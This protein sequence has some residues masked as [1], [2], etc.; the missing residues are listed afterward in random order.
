MLS[1]LSHHLESLAEALESGA[2]KGQTGRLSLSDTRRLSPVITLTPVPCHSSSPGSLGLSCCL[3]R[4]VLPPPLRP[5]MLP[6][7][8]CPMGPWWSSSL[9]PTSPLHSPFIL[10]TGSVGV[11]EAGGGESCSSEEEDSWGNAP[12]TALYRHRLRGRPRLPASEMLPLSQSFSGNFES[13]SAPGSNGRS[14]SPLPPRSPD[15]PWR[16]FP[17]MLHNSATRTRYF[18]F[19][20]PAPAHKVRA[21]RSVSHGLDGTAAA[22]GSSLLSRRPRRQPAQPWPSPTASCAR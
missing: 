2:R 11:G 9:P 21:G 15:S 19:D 13:L 10:V 16:R 22:A 7:S 1:Y 18:N 3:C 5:R 12:P 8:A 14:R 17:S 4:L 20:A 6:F